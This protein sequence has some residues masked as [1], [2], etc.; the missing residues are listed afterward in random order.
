[1]ILDSINWKSKNDISDL[2]LKLRLDSRVSDAI[3]ICKEATL[4]FG[5]DYFYP[6]ILG[7]LYLSEGEVEKAR[8]SFLE[9]L[10]RIPPQKKFFAGFAQRYYRARKASSAED[11]QRFAGV[12]YSEVLAGNV[13]DYWAKKIEDLI[14]DD[15]VHKQVISPKGESLVN[16]FNDSKSAPHLIG[17]FKKLE[18]DGI[19]EIEYIL[20]SYLLKA[21]LKGALYHFYEY[22]VS[23]YEKNGE[24]DKAIKLVLKLVQIKRQNTIVRSLFR[25]CRRLNKYE[26][27]DGVLLD[28]PG[29]FKTQDFNVTY[30]LV[31]YWEYKDEFEN[32]KKTLLFIEKAGIDSLPIQ[33][34]VKNFYLRF[35]LVEDVNRVDLSI[36]ALTQIKIPPNDRF[37]EEIEETQEGVG[38]AIQELRIAL[39]Q[40]T[41]LAAMTDLTRGISHELGQPITNIRYTVQ[42]Y[43]RKLASNFNVETLN[44]VFTSIMEE[45]ERMGSLIGR[46]SP[47]TSVQ[48]HQEKF[49]VYNLIQSRI[50]VADARL[51]RH[52]ISVALKG[53]KSLLINSDPVRFE[54][55]INNLL[56]NSIDSLAHAKRVK[57]KQI[58]ISLSKRKNLVVIEFADTG[59][60][61]PLKNRGQIFDPF[62]TT[63]PPGKGEGLGL[64]IVWNIVKIMGG[65]ITLDQ[66]YTKGA[67]FIIS[68]PI[69]IVAEGE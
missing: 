11:T 63:K 49:A 38:S 48:S 26:I 50:S 18:K 8:E 61:I 67:K 35:G 31:Y 14:K 27:V 46:L 47:I 55:V 34:T 56:F 64:F 25:L 66:K 3:S 69:D 59:S 52:R 24:F 60:G 1:M 40:K 62:F 44:K 45:T 19:V 41:R 28:Y 30:E 32:V 23:F 22:V 6:K 12:I 5:A 10:R 42:F 58:N 17:L 57:S 36:K 29:I 37:V 68:L 16:A 65:R 9:F 4:K 15:L 39:K 13:L 33:R 51:R 53:N 20:D 43:E 2:I 21:E 7:D 54:Q